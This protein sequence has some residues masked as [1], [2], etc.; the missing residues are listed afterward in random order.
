MRRL[1][2]LAAVL[3]LMAGKCGEGKGVSSPANGLAALVGSKWVLQTLNGAPVDQALGERTPYLQL[4]EGEQFTGQGGCNQ[5][6]GSFSIEGTVLRFGQVGATKMFCQDTKDL[7][8]KFTAALR[9]TDS[10]VMDGDVLRLMQAG[11]E[12]AVLRAQ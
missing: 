2:P 6:F 11:R 1:L 10:F 5:L 4:A 9:A 3:L 7:E 8:G 12:L